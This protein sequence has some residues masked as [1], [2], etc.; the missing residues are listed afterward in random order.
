MN[1][2]LSKIDSNINQ[3]LAQKQKLSDKRIQELNQ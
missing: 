1:G 2:K 3:T